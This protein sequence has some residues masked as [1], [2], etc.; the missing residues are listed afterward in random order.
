[1][2]PSVVK[3][4]LAEFPEAEQTKI[5]SVAFDFEEQAARL[6]A[7]ILNLPYK[8]EVIPQPGLNAKYEEQ[9]A[10]FLSEHPFLVGGGREFRN[11]VFEAACLAILIG[12]GKPNYA[13]L[14]N[15]YAN[16]RRSNLYLIQML[17]QVAPDCN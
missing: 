10:F 2:L 1:V 14:V 12:S 11:A 16:G 15:T 5:E 3:G 9:L 4:L 6:I 13:N 17:N 7:Y 8:M